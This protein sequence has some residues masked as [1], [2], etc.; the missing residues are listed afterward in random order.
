MF[1]VEVDVTL[2]TGRR[3]VDDE[4]SDLIEV[5]VDGLDEAQLEPSVGTR[6]IGDD[7]GLRVGVTVQ[8]DDEFSALTAGLVAVDAALRSAG[9][10]TTGVIVPSHLRSEVVPLQPA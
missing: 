5:V 10:G 8:G 2:G 6:R 7:L 1:V 4:I 9:I 3:L